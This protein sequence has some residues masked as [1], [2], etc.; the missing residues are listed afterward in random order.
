[1]RGERQIEGERDERNKTAREKT[2]DIK[3]GDR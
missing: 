1:M 3:A 2:V